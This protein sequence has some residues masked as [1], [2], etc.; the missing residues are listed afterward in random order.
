MKNAL[1]KIGLIIATLAVFVALINIY[2]QIVGYFAAPKFEKV[3][4]TYTDH[5]ADLCMFVCSYHDTY[6]YEAKGLQKNLAQNVVDVM[7]A[8]GYQL[9]N[10]EGVNCYGASGDD[11]IFVKDGQLTSVSFISKTRLPDVSS[12]SVGCERPYSEYKV[13]IDTFN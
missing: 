8:K 9:R 2:P 11:Y 6:W 3:H 10:Q 7:R 4:Y 12:T 5:H 1:K 13:S